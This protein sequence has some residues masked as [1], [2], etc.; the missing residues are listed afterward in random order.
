M[1]IT[2]LP[3][4][5]VSCKFIFCGFLWLKNKLIDGDRVF[6]VLI[7]H[8]R[9][10]SANCTGW[11]NAKICFIT[12]LF[13]VAL[14][15][16]LRIIYGLGNSRKFRYLPID[17]LGENENIWNCKCAI[18]WA[19]NP[20][21]YNPKLGRIFM[22]NHNSLI[23]G[24]IKSILLRVDSF[25]TKCM[26]DKYVEVSTKAAGFETSIAKEPTP[27]EKYFTILIH[28]SRFVTIYGIKPVLWMVP[29]CETDFS[30]SWR[31]W[32]ELCAKFTLS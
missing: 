19:T 21:L 6:T 9:G 13:C 4:I 18:K 8:F 16:G 11:N 27:W 1:A 10:F 3:E 2:L 29:Y 5:K 14:V 12:N 25:L 15:V 31:V 28:V 32:Y 26:C 24:C 30:S 22:V 17:L 23:F 20:E 7:T